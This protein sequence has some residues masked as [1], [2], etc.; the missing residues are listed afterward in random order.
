V[1]AGTL[2]K[3]ESLYIND[4]VNLHNLPSELALCSSLQIMSI[5]NCPLS[6]IPAE[7]VAEGPSLVI[8]VINNNLSTPVCLM[9]V[10]L[11]SCISNPIGFGSGQI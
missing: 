2:E 11:D 10:M 4:N 3:L 6:Q 9:R 5:E 1:L 8:Q 7:I